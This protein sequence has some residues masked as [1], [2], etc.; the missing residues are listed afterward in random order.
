[1][2]KSG[3]GPSGT[4]ANTVSQFQKFAMFW[5]IDA[6]NMYQVCHVKFKCTFGGLAAD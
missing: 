2:T 1:M 6:K 5:S 4:S 3:S